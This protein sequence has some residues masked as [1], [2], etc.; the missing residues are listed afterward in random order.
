MPTE[1]KPCPFCGHA[2]PHLATDDLSIFVECP[3]CGAT[4]PEAHVG[5]NTDG[6]DTEAAALLFW[7]GRRKKE[8]MWP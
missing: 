6:T 1:M 4:G 5:L 8:R 3:K 7:N 2:D